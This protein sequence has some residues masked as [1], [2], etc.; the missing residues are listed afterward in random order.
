MR[1]PNF[2]EWKCFTHPGIRADETGQADDTAVR[3][4]FGHLGYPA[5]V[6]FP[7]L[8]REAQITVEPRSDIVSVQTVG[9]NTM[10]DQVVLQGERQRGL[11]STRQPWNHVEF[12]RTLYYKW[13]FVIRYFWVFDGIIPTSTFRHGTDFYR[14]PEIVIRY[15]LYGGHENDD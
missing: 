5:D 9:G 1:I 12:G 13:L 3:E 10:V 15:F 7:V 6:L 14:F 11:T 8:R 2:F 4:Q